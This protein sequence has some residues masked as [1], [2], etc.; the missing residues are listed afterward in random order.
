MA[1]RSYIAA[2]NEQSVSNIQRKLA[3]ISTNLRLALPEKP[4]FFRNPEYAQM[5]Q[6]KWISDSLSAIEVFTKTVVEEI[7]PDSFVVV[8]GEG[9]V[10]EGI[11][12]ESAN[13]SEKVGTFSDTDTPKVSENQK[14]AETEVSAKQSTKK[15][16]K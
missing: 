16:G 8:T 4:Q 12:V 15:R 7:E 1:S 11:V 13:L 2:E 6:L 14:D 5:V 3:E 10:S 9:Q